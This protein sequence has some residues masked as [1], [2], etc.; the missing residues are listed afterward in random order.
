MP[1]DVTLNSALKDLNCGFRVSAAKET[2]KPS[3]GIVLLTRRRRWVNPAASFARLNIPKPLTVSA[4]QKP[5]ALSEGT[6]FVSPSQTAIPAVL[7]ML[8]VL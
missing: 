6:I 8:Q 7:L 1:S 2:L 3:Y 5:G 4:L